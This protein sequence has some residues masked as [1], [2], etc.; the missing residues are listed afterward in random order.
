MSPARYGV[1]GLV[2]ICLALAYLHPAMARAATKRLAL[3]VAHPFGSEDL[4]PLRYTAHDVD[5]MRDVLELLGDFAP[6]DVVISFGESAEE[7][8]Q[9]LHEM[10]Q[11]IHDIKQTGDSTLFVFYYSGH[12][13]DGALRLGASRLSLGRVK[14][15]IEETNAS[16]RIALLDSCRSGSITQLKGVSKGDPIAV[17]VEP[18]NH[19][20]GLVLITSSSAHEDAQE[21]DSIQGSFF[22]HFL[23]TGMR[24]A[25]DQN[26]DG[27]VT[28]SEAYS[29]AYDHTVS[30]TIGTRGGIQ[31]PAYHFDLHGTGDIVLTRPGDPPSALAFA[32]AVNGHF[33]V[34]DLGRRVVVAEFNKISGRPLHMGVAPG[35]Y[36]VKKR[37]ANG[38]LIQQVR[39]SQGDTVSIDMQRMQR[40]AFA[41]DYAKGDTV[42]LRQAM[43]GKIGI[44]FSAQV[45]AQTFFSSPVRD[46]FL[47]NLSLLQLKVDFDNLLR[48]HLGL[49]FDVGLGTG[50]RQTLRINDS[51]VGSIEEDTEVTELTAGALSPCTIPTETGSWFDAN[52]RLGVIRVNRRFFSTKLP[53][54]SFTTLTPG[55][56]A[57][58]RFRLNR[59]L[60][61]GVATQVH[62]MF[63]SGDESVSLA[64]LNAGAF[65]SAVL[66]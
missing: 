17:S 47:P 31:H 57:G 59:W 44:R 50:G 15:L 39:A 43:H 18:S 4:L 32:P 2:G 11:R 8:E 56:G 12:A 14:S 34:F 52:A 60:Q 66:R 55:L 33:V 40:I 6:E 49:Q 10:R 20:T 58:V 35:L 46:A 23:T 30:G 38:L 13:K 9:R 29:F 42:S 19:Q 48:R 16:L 1:H 65:L 45:S 28:L 7:V 22:T 62:Y 37:E 61:A 51:L 41:D 24:G 27:S 3:L 63:F 53:Q 64:Y 54:Q 26:D 5:R 25:A 36:A 21:S